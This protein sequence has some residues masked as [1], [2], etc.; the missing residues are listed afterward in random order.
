LLAAQ[1]AAR[2]SSSL[3]PLTSCSPQPPIPSTAILTI[4]HDP[5]PVSSRAAASL[6]P[7]VWRCREEGD[8]HPPRVLPRL[9]GNLP[10]ALRAY[11]HEVVLLGV[12]D[13][14]PR[15]QVGSASTVNITDVVPKHLDAASGHPQP[16]RH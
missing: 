2:A 14:R 13:L 12:E 3:R 11:D 9:V 8:P 7:E 15:A 5:P 4:S 6:S 16:F 10:V 1:Q